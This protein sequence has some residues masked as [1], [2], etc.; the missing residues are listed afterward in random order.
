MKAKFKI[1][2]AN[3]DKCV[4]LSFKENHTDLRKLMPQVEKALLAWGFKPQ[5]LSQYF[6]NDTYIQTLKDKIDNL[7]EDLKHHKSKVF[8]LPFKRAK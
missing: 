8:S 1:I 4:S 7:K 5:Q 6:N 2:I 3:G